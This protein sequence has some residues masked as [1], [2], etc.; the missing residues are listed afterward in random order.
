MV[1]K[2]QGHEEPSSLMR[3]CGDRLLKAILP[4]SERHNIERK[5]ILK[6]L[7]AVFTTRTCESN[8]F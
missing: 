7:C 1:Y 8:T 2:N 5:S 3:N 6:E 4:D